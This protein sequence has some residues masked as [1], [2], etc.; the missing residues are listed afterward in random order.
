MVSE[1]CEK[2]GGD[3]KESDVAYEIARYT[4][5]SGMIIFYQYRSSAG[6]PC[7]RCR[8][9]KMI[10]P[11]LADVIVWLQKRSGYN[12]LFSVKGIGA[13]WTDGQVKEELVKRWE[14]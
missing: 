1:A 8:I 4:S 5:D 13:G 2:F 9:G 10:K 12:N 7:I 3:Y 11:D 14:A 6:H